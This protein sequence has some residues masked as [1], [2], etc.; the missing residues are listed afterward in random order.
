MTSE[1]LVCIGRKERYQFECSRGIAQKR[2][3]FLKRLHKAE[4]VGRQN[5][6]E[7]K[8]ASLQLMTETAGT[9]VDCTQGREKVRPSTKIKS[10]LPA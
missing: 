6:S 5:N 2:D 3:S 10:W 7:E 9:P 8:R 1:D 4:E